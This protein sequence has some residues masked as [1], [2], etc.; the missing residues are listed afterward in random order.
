M[1]RSMEVHKERRLA[2]KS[3]DYD[4]IGSKPYSMRRSKTVRDEY[5]SGTEFKYLSTLPKVK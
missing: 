2:S 3:A 1:Y 5:D 4:D